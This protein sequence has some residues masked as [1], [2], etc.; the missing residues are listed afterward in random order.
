MR[1]CSFLCSLEIRV[2]IKA[3]CSCELKNKSIKFRGGAQNF[4]VEFK[5]HALDEEGG[6]LQ[7]ISGI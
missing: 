1:L 3:Y 5:G 7:F 2:L 4:N 6:A